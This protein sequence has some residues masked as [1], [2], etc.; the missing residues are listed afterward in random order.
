MSRSL[1]GLALFLL[2]ASTALSQTGTL[3]GRV[4]DSQTGVPVPGAT[5]QLVGTGTGAAADASGYFVLAAVPVDTHA[6]RVSSVGYEPITRTVAVY[7]GERVVLDV[8]LSEQTASLGA[9]SVVSRR[10]GFVPTELTSASKLGARPLET[11]HSVSVLTQD[12][13]EVQDAT[14]LAEALRYT[15]GVQGEA[16]GFE[17]RFTWIK[18]RGFDATQTG[19]YRDGL[20]LRNVNYAVGYNVEPYGMERV[21]VLRGPASVL[22]GAGSP[23]GVVAFSSKRP[24]LVAQ[25]EVAVEAGSF[26]RLQA[27]A[28][29]SGPVPGTDALQYRVTGLLRD[30]DTQVEF[31]QNDRLYVAPALTWRPGASTT[32]TVLGHVQRDDTGASQALPIEGTLEANTFGAVPTDFYTGAPGTDR[33]DRNEW[34]ASSLFE[35]R[36]GDTWTLR[37]NARYYASD[38]DDVTVYSTGLLDDRRTLTRSIFGTFGSLDGLALDNQARAQFASGATETTIL[39]GLDIQRLDVGLQQ[40]FGGAPS[41]DLFS[42]DYDQ[43]VEAPP[44]FADTQTDQT[45]TGLYLQGQTK[46]AERLVLSLGGRYDWAKTETVNHMADGAVTEQNDRAFTGRAGVVY[47]SSIGVSPYV[48]YAQSFLPQV[49]LDASGE[50]FSPERGRQTEVG[51]KVQPPGVNGLLTVALFNLT[52]DDFL[53]YDPNTSLQVQTGQVRSRG[54]EMEAVASLTNGLDVTA[55]FTALDVEIT[56]SANEAEIGQRPTQIPNRTASLWADYSVPSGPLAGLGVGAGVRHI[57]ATWGNVPNT[58]ETA[59]TTLADAALYMDVRRL[60]LSVNVQNVF[61]DTYVASAF[62][63]SSTLVTFGAGRQVSVGLRAKF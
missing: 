17:P 11:P 31:V 30:S 38:L 41:L 1:F 52:R 62:A 32:W 49:G 58:I 53:Q 7:E 56:E 35:H 45:Q 50:P 36:I 15:P 28:D 33:Y 19:L 61:D 54:V 42:P 6:V 24:T 26:G 5:V 63:R 3:A 27:Q 16:W 22:Y 29:L 2:T 40:T 39:G 51:V 12:Q 21:E 4:T 59:A 9:I 14:T 46:W 55:G 10:G 47:L 37:Q 20:Q 34:S 43:Q 25:R 13:L 18:V 23:G 8:A 48:S 60:R 44:T 57:G